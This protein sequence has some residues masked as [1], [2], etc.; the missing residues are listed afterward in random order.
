MTK[1]VFTP[2]YR[3]F[4]EALIRARKHQHITQTALAKALRRPQSYVSKYEHG[5]RRLDLIETLDILAVLHVCPADF[6]ADLSDST[7]A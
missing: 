7:G 4:L 5:E 3:R 1:S 2:R 6:L